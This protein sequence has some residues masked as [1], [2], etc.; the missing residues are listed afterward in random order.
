VHDESLEQ[1]VFD[2]VIG[3]ADDEDEGGSEIWLSVVVAAA[4]AIAISVPGARVL[5]GRGSGRRSPR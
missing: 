1:I 2:V 3:V 5:R 4:S